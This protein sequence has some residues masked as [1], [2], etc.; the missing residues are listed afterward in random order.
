MKY[1]PPSDS[2]APRTTR[3]SLHVFKGDDQIGWLD[4]LFLI[5]MLDMIS[6]NEEKKA[7]FLI[8]RE[9]KVNV[10]LVIYI[11]VVDIITDHPSCS[12]QHAVIQFRKIPISFAMGLESPKFLIR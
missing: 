1:S 10:P 7:H 9:H 5:M 8:G 12:S 4:N 3:W 11:Q 2:F 6:L